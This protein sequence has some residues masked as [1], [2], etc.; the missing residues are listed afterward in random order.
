MLYSICGFIEENITCANFQ[1]PYITLSF[2]YLN[3]RKIFSGKR[4]VNTYSFSFK[5]EVLSNVKKRS[6]K[7]KIT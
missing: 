7:S 2:S 3:S 5:T 4:K 1:F 6:P